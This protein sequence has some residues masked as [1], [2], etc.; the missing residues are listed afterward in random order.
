MTRVKTWKP[1]NTKLVLFTS[2]VQSVGKYSVYRWV[3]CLGGCMSI[4]GA[5][6]ICLTLLSYPPI[7]DHTQDPYSKTPMK[8]MLKT[9]VKTLAL[10]PNHGQ[11]E[12]LVLKTYDLGS[13]GLSK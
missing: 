11:D 6:Y 9:L 1:T 4:C 12:D 2:I 5:S 7:K 13:L 10:D 3:W 8:T